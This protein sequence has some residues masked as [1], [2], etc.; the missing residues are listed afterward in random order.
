M[1]NNNQQISMFDEENL[2]VELQKTPNTKIDV[3]KLDF[4]GAESL[5]WSELFS[6]F[7]ELH[8]ITYSS[9]INFLYQL[10]SKFQSAEVIFGCEAVM[11][12]SIQKIFAFQENL[13][14]MIRS[15]LSSS[16][17][18]LLTKID[19]GSVKLYVAHKQISHE[20]IYL[21]SAK[22]GRKR[23]VMGSANM[24][25]NA[26]TGVQREN[27]CYIDGDEAYNY[28]LDLFEE[29]KEDCTGDLTKKAIESS[30][31][32]ENI[33]ELPI[34]QVVKT[35][36]AV[37]IE[38]DKNG[39][40]DVRFIL[41]VDK[42]AERIKHAMP[43]KDKSGKILITPTE[44]V[45]IKRQ[46][47]RDDEKQKEVRKEHPQLVVDVV[48]GAVSLNGEPIDLNPTKEE[49]GSDVNLFLQYMDGYKAFHGD[50]EGMQYRYYEFA[51]WFFCS[52]F[53]GIMRDY[54]IRY[55][56]QRLPY[57][58]FGLIY[59]K[60]KA[61][62]TSF[63]ETLLKAMIGQKPKISAPDFTRSTIDALKNM[64]QG[65][66]IIVDD[67]T[68]I[69]FNQHAIE[70]IKNDDFGFSDRKTTYPAVVIS[71]NEDVKAVSP[72]VIRRTVI[73]KVEA[74]LTNTEVM[75]N[76]TVR[77]VQS[78]LKTAFYRE[79]LR[80][81]IPEV[82]NLL[83]II[84]DKDAER[85]PD[86][87][88]VSSDVLFDII[89]ENAEIVPDY[90]RHLS[91]IDYF[92]EEVTGKSVK[93]EIQRAWDTSRAYFLVNEKINEL[94]YSASQA[95]EADR[96]LKEL[97]ETLEARKTRDWIIMNLKEAQSFFEREF[98]KSWI[99]KVKER[100]R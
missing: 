21:L 30:D 98:K 42:D 40:E 82:Q 33:D 65:A 16:K 35:K 73:C 81:M 80:R 51:N 79:Y 60:S 67:L 7:D 13:I 3:V 31:L 66:P 75:E 86:I 56:Q 96:L 97:P 2:S 71:A 20:K 11:S 64:V 88:K 89:S 25:Y 8:A 83:E 32:A 99:E 6:D 69:R 48:N 84:K 46:V 94:K 27:I 50:S 36:Q 91:L 47:K 26:F 77:K 39:L 87:L 59:G 17:S 15:D 37:Y 55:D 44:I 92:G 43:K 70:T 78:G 34:S 4:I 76:N 90:I 18:D 85:A 23:V 10:L 1:S 12:D 45:K 74:G 68:N 24:S 95:Y 49:V 93:K 22:D 9:G 61:G 19:N 63:L 14:E 53:M 38:P 54:A 28:Y 52:P 57:P 72:E 62:K 41:K 29:Y 5:T 100:G 58:V